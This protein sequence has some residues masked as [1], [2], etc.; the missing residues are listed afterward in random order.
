MGSIVRSTGTVFYSLLYSNSRRG[1]NRLKH[2]HTHE[3][4]AFK[5]YKTQ[6]VASNL[7]QSHFGSPP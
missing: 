3:A 4:P 6:G 5:Q 2:T 7:V 1:L